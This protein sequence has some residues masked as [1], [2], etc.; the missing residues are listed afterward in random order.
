MDSSGLIACGLCHTLCGSSRG[1]GKTDVHAFQ[2]I[3]TDD[4]IDGGGLSCTGAT[5][6]NQQAV[7]HSLYDCL[8]LLLIQLYISAFL[9]ANKLCFHPLLIH[10]IL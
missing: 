4:R 7:F 10:G 9:K 1:S 5:G 2:L 6:D 3:V 8:A